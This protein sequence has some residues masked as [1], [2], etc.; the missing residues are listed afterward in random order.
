M[1]DALELI[2]HIYD[3]AFD[4]ALW[5]EVLIRLTDAVGGAEVCMFDS[6]PRT[7]SAALIAPRHDPDYVRSMR[8][9]WLRREFEASSSTFGQ[10]LLGAPAGQV[11]DAHQLVPDEFFRTDFY[12]EWWRPQGLSLFGIGTKWRVGPHEWGF[13]FVHG[14]S[15][16]GEFEVEN[17]KLFGLIAPHLVRAAELHHR[18]RH[19]K[20]EQESALVGL[21]RPDRGVIFVD[22]TARVVYANDTAADLIRARDGLLVDRSELTALDSDASTVLRRM[23]AGCADRRLTKGGSVDVRRGERL[24]LHI[25]V[26]PFRATRWQDRDAWLGF[27]RPVAILIVNDPELERQTYKAHLQE[28][29]RLTPA[30]TEVALEISK[31]DGRDAAAARLAITPGTLRIHLQRVFEK[32][33]VHRQAELVRLLADARGRR[34]RL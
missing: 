3:A 22:A 8:D 18:L 1:T 27:L 19:F 2:G 11:L 13:C 17:A 12:N 7:H 16:P 23:I 29:F 30:E 34:P 21:N 33:G 14:S 24:P 26:A 5:P 15:G 28:E 6:D 4:A 20:L 32:T 25:L 31:G 10:R 9:E